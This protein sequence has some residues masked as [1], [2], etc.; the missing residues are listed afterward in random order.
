MGKYRYVNLYPILSYFWRKLS[1]W[2]FGLIIFINRSDWLVKKE[3]I[4]KSS[5]IYVLPGKEER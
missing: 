1:K 4:A 5:Q 2:F 3:S